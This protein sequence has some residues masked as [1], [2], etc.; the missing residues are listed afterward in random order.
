M[1]QDLLNVINVTEDAPKVH[2][3]IFDFLIKSDLK[4]DDPD[5]K[6][7]GSIDNFFINNRNEKI[8][9]YDFEKA[10]ESGWRNSSFIKKSNEK[11]YA[12]AL[13]LFE[14]FDQKLF[15]R[16]LEREENMRRS[17][18]SME[19]SLYQP[20]EHHIGRGIELRG[21]GSNNYAVSH[22]DYDQRFMESCNKDRKMKIVI[23]QRIEKYEKL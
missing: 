15:K 16:C 20:S 3:L 19:L 5:E 13:A 2:K 4:I 1:N 9:S 22:S 10:R 12:N 11:E 6:F 8:Y 7:D 14:K 21:S 23:Q 18:D 17:I